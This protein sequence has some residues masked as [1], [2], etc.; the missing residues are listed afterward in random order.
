[1]WQLLVFIWE[2][3]ILKNIEEQSEVNVQFFKPWG[4]E[5]KW[6][7]LHDKNN[8]ALVPLSHV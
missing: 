5:V 4:E 3:G 7:Q 2:N 1:M 6:F 8:V